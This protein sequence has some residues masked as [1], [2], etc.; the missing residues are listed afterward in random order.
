MARF[1]WDREDIWAGYTGTERIMSWLYWDRDYIWAFILRQRG[2]VDWLY[3]ER[4]DIL[5]GYTGTEKKYG[6]VMLG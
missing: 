3:W 6:P 5:T 4:D 2:Y 1:Y